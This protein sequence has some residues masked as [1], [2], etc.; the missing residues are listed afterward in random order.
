MFPNEQASADY[1]KGAVT[2]QAHPN[3]GW[4]RWKLYSLEVTRAEI[5]RQQNTKPE[6][7]TTAAP[8]IRPGKW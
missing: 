3:F 6:V 2:G 7:G 8:V 1:L 4:G 5:V